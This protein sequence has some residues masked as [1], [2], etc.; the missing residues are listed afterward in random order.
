MFAGEHVSGTIIILLAAAVAVALIAHRLRIPYV[1]AL[2]IAGLAL[3][4]G[5]AIHAPA[6]TQGLLYSVFL[7]GLIFE[8]AFHMDLRALRRN[9][10][11]LVA[12]TVPGV[13][14]SIFA[15]A[16]L[17][18]WGSRALA[19]AS[20]ITWPTGLVFGAIIAATDP[21][22]VVAVF[23]RFGVPDRLRLLV[24]GES[25][26]NDGTAIVALSLVLA[27]V[28]GH[29]VSVLTLAGE[30]V[31]TVGLGVLVGTVIGGAAWFAISRIDDATLEITLTSVTAYGAFLGAEALHVSGVLATVAAGLLCGSC[32]ARG[33][34]SPVTR[35]AV[36]SYWEYVAFVLNSL[37]FLLLGLS[38]QPR[39]L[40]EAWPLILVAYGVVLVVREAVLLG[41]S[42]VVHPTRQRL[43][44]RWRPALLWGGLRG[45]LSMVLALGLAPD[46]PARTSI[47]TMT[48]GVV[49]LSILIQGLTMGP[50][51]RALGIRP[52]APPEAA[53]ERARVALLV[54]EAAR[55]QLDALAVDPDIDPSILAPPREENNARRMAARAAMRRANGDGVRDG[56]GDAQ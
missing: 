2:V 6:L 11:T 31:T 23:R 18:A 51:L 26:L 41:V 21:I 39:T 36:S 8:A 56:A 48:A 1:V 43:P 29:G 22:A 47:V 34:M 55:E 40:G 14:V 9:A 12:L 49:I 32:A 13:A 53:Y 17:L 5:H 54:S 16:G 46:V 50:V 15:T 10:G 30:F 28:Q 33:G 38:V 3:G 24:E 25:L 45:A 42:A 19:P 37:V 7:P 44:R 27:A 52:E 35:R 4:A 20:A